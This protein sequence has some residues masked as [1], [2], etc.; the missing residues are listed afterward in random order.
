MSK[1]KYN[2]VRPKLRRKMEILHLCPTIIDTPA[3]QTGIE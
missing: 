2:D 1:N 3:A